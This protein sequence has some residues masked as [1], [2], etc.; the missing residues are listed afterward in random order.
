M[1]ELFKNYCVAYATKITIK[2]I[3]MSQKFALFFKYLNISLILFL[4]GV[5][6]TNHLDEM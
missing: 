2:S 1:V 3:H 6:H 4:D 5:Y